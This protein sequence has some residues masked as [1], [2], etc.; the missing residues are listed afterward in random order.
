MFNKHTVIIILV[1]LTITLSYAASPEQPNS[2]PQDP[3]LLRSIID[4]A[5]KG[6]PSAQFKLGEM[7]SKGNG[8]PQ[9]CNEA[10]KWFAKAADQG[11]TEAQFKVGEMYYKGNGVPQDCNEACKRFTKIAVKGHPAAQCKLGEMYSDGNGAPQD[12]NEASKWFLKAA[13]KGNA[14][15]QAHL[16]L[17]YY[18]GKGVIEDYVEA[19]KWALLAGMN[20]EDVSKIKQD[21]TAR[22][23]PV[24]IAEA[25][26]LAKEFV[27]RQENTKNNSI[28]KPNLPADENKDTLRVE[29]LSKKIQ[30]MNDTIELT[31]QRINA[32]P[33]ITYFKLPHRLR[34]SEVSEIINSLE[35]TNKKKQL[36]LEQRINYNK[37]LSLVE[38]YSD[39]GFSVMDVKKKI[40]ECQGQIDRTDLVLDD[41]RAVAQA[42]HD[43]FNITP[44]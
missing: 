12:Y 18:E 23:N 32:L 22:M 3:N 26:K 19:Y 7:Y 37:I 31:G 11:H 29:R 36:L 21:L 6:Y 24:Q 4:D 38:K 16:A 40:I 8:V 25:Q 43:K 17:I 34:R 39:L 33:A 10:F 15:A 27:A 42:N 41:L 9:D 44:R 35:V 20:G 5:N 13:D 1:L 28:T 30:E 2:M 14:T